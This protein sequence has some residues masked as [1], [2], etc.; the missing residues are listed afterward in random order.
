[1][2]EVKQKVIQI[3]NDQVIQTPFSGSGIIMSYNQEANIADV[4]Y[5][6]PNGQEMVL[7]RIPVRLSEGVSTPH[8]S[9]GTHVAMIFPDTNV[10]QAIIIAIIDFNHMNNTRAKMRHKRKGSYIPNQISTRGAF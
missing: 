6:H 8:L 9:S 5:Q 2:S 1:M 4:M 10:F 3:V 7:E